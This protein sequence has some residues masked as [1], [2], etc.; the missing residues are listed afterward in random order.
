M[1]NITVD[2]NIC[3]IEGENEIR[4]IKAI[5]ENTEDIHHCMQHIAKT[6]STLCAIQSV[7][8]QHVLDCCYWLGRSC[9][10]IGA[11]KFAADHIKVLENE[12]N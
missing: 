6:I 2:H 1:N 9:E 7:N 8:E 5:T 3:S 10:I 4:D 12:S 11:V